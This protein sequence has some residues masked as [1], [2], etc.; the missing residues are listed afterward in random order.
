MYCYDAFPVKIWKYKFSCINLIDEILKDFNLYP[1]KSYSN[2][3]GWQSL[4]NLHTDG[5]FLQLV[6]EIMNNATDPF[7]YYST[8]V[9]Q[10]VDMWSNINPPGSLNQQHDHGNSMVLSGVAYFQ[11]N[12]SNGHLHFYNPNPAAKFSVLDVQNSTTGQVFTI[13]VEPGDLLFFPCWLEHYTSINETDEIRASVA[14][15]IGAL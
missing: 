10:I 2:V 3:G 8:K 5:R 13:P 9:P 15:N 1:E 14:F 6:T 11:T 4:K 12:K 7:K